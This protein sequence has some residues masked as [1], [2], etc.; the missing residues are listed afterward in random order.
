V[1]LIAAFLLIFAAGTA[2]GLLTFWP[3][4]RAKRRTWLAEELNLT[5]RQREQMHEIW[6]QAMKASGEQ[7]HATWREL[8]KQRDEAIVALLTDEQR[9]QYE[10]I[11]QDYEG[12]LQE[13]H[14]Q[15]RRA[16][17]QAVERTKQILTPEQN[18]KY[19]ELRKRRGGWGPGRRGPRRRRPGSRPTTRE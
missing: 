11:I 4:P 3:R 12:K 16:I 9:A 15:R 8:V 2:V 6:S 7:R 19:D 18:K 5:P 10:Q 13:H 1:I 14:R 17:E